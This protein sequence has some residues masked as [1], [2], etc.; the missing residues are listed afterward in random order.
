MVLLAPDEA[1]FAVGDRVE[2]IP[3]HVGPAVNLIDALAIGQAGRVI[4]W[5]PVAARGNVRLHDQR[6]AEQAHAGG[7]R[8][9]K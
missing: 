3:N 6:R 8:R 5:W 4:D 1:D 9:E 7:E 2:I